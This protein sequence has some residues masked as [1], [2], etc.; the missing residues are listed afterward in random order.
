MSEKDRSVPNH[1]PVPLIYYCNVSSQPSVT[2]VNNREM[3]PIYECAE[4][5][6]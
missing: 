2:V 1:V 3:H 6:W 4:G 5:L